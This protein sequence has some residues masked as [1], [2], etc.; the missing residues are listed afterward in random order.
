VLVSGCDNTR[1]ARG[2][3][4]GGVTAGGG[5]TSGGADTAGGA[6]TSGGGVTRGGAETTGR[7]G[8]R[9]GGV[10]SGGAVSEGGA[11]TEGGAVT[12]GGGVTS[13]G[14]VTGGGAETAGRGGTGGGPTS[15]AA[16]VG[17]ARAP[18]APG[19]DVALLVSGMVVAPALAA[20]RIL[21]SAGIATLVLNIPAIKP[22]GAATVLAAA[23]ALPVISAPRASGARFPGI[24]RLSRERSC[25]GRWRDSDGWRPRHL[26]F[27]SRPAGPID[28]QTFSRQGLCNA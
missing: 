10:S 19:S 16:A 26:R 5:V 12:R 7:G 24:T 4:G 17:Q 1:L 13:G 23:A 3:T 14:G 2:T 8:T 25:A 21:R 28:W 27:R 9:G 6:V 22:L 15:V 11:E 18:E 20:A